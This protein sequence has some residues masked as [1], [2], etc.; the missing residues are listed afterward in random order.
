MTY[1]QLQ[2]L[3]WKDLQNLT[4]EQLLQSVDTLYSQ[5][6]DSDLPL[7]AHAQKVF[8]Q[9]ARRMPGAKVPKVVGKAVGMLKQEMPGLAKAFGVGAAAE[10]GKECIQALSHTL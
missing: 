3:Q 2:G 9:L 5:Y 7:T 8:A 10:L 1:E 4:Y 6:K